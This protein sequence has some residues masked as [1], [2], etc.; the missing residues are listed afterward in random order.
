MLWNRAL[1]ERLLGRKTKGLVH[2]V[3]KSRRPT[4]RYRESE[5]G[6]EEE[7]CL[8]IFQRDNHLN[9]LPLCVFLAVGPCLVGDNASCCHAFLA[10]R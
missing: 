8:G 6:K 9:P 7:V 3:P 5:V 10:F 2:Q 1:Q 4:I